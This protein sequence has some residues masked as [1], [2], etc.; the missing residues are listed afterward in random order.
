[1]FDQLCIILYEFCKN[2]Q[3]VA[4]A[5]ELCHTY[6][7]MGDCPRCLCQM[8]SHL[9]NNVLCASHLESGTSQ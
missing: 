2:M 7:M 5:A 1:M 9:A 6:R 3:C 8:Y 4:I